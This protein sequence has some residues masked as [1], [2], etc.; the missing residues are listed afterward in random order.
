MCLLLELNGIGAAVGL[1]A[2]YRRCAATLN[3]N[4]N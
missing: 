2:P 1:G 3:K 4:L